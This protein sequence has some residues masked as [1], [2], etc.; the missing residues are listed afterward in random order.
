MSE[1]EYKNRK[2]TRIDV[3]ISVERQDDPEQRDAP[4]S[5]AHVTRHS[6]TDA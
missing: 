1:T 6:A 4:R 2:G 3:S 5:H